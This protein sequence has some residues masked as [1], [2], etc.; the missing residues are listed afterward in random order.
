MSQ[1]I[2]SQAILSQSNRKCLC[3]MHEDERKKERI[4]VLKNL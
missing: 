4:D 2:L 3:T 1:T